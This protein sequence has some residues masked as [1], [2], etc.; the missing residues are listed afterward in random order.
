MLIYKPVFVGLVETEIFICK[1]FKSLLSIQKQ[2]ISREHEGCRLITMIIMV[3]INSLALYYNFIRNDP[4]STKPVLTL[5]YK[6]STICIG[7]P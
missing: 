6:L 3:S 7:L 5:L 1:C 4:S 2:E